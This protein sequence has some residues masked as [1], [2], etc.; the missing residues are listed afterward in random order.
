MTNNDISA[1]KIVLAYHF[2]MR[3]Q[4]FAYETLPPTHHL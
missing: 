3:T 1:L 4:F 2:D